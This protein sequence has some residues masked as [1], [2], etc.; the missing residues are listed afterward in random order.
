MRFGRDIICCNCMYLSGYRYIGDGDTD[1]HEF[2]KMVG[3]HRS[4]TQSG[5]LGG[6]TPRDPQNPK[7]WPSKKRTSLKDKSQGYMSIRDYQ[8]NESFLKLYNMGR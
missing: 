5:I 6:G 3:L 8:L 1:R 7:L 4:R 2:C